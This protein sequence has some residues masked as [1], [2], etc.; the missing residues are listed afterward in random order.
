MMLCNKMLTRRFLSRNNLRRLFPSSRMVLTVFPGK[1]NL[2][3]FHN[4]VLFQMYLFQLLVNG[5]SSLV[6]SLF[7]Y[8][9]DYSFK[10]IIISQEYFFNFCLGDLTFLTYFLSILHRI[11]F[12]LSFFLFQSLNLLS[13]LLYCGLFLYMF[14]FSWYNFS[15]RFLSVCFLKHKTVPIRHFISETWLPLL[16][17]CF[18]I[19]F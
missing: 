6:F 1:S 7:H 19:I 17:L 9:V 12:L 18:Y 16:V 2:I 14:L 8:T 15:P 13:T 3:A 4:G 5:L 10:F 11:Q